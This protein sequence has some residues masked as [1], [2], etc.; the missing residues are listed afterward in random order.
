M[1]KLIIYYSFDGNTR[2]IANAIAE[3][4]GAEILELKP[5]KEVPRNFMRYVW[6]G[7]QVT[8][9]S[10]PELEP[11]L[12]KPNEYGLIFIG[13][14]VWAFSYAPPLNTF[15]SENVIYG[16]NIALFCCHGGMPAKTLEKMRKKLEFKDNKQRN[17]FM[18]EADFKEPLKTDK[19]GSAKRAKVWARNI[20][21]N[22][23]HK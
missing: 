5:K 15:F 9:G 1:K 19:E 2:H 11:F 12:I 23:E 20:V 8:L 16:K 18:A 14:P 6:G 10:K 21:E 22:L 7:R 3:E 17:F 13:T 4:I